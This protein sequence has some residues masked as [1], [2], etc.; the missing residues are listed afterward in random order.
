MATTRTSSMTSAPS[1]MLSLTAGM[2]AGAV[3][4]AV[5]YPAEFVKTKA[6]F[7]GSKAEAPKLTSII[8]QTI[9]QK[10]I[11]GLYSGAGALIAGNALK[12]GVRFMTYD[13]IKALLV[14]ERGKLSPVNG[15]LAGLG[16]GVCEAVI[17]VTPSETIKTKLIHD[18]ASL[19]PKYSGM[20]NGA[21]GIYKS[22]GVAGMYRG[23]VPTIMKQGANSMV[24][25]SSF[26]ALQDLALRFKSATTGGAK[27]LGSSETFTVGA[28]AGLITVYCT[29]PFDNIKTRMQALGAE[30]RYSNSLDCFTKIIREEGTTRLW[31]GTTP[32]LARL[33]L[34]GGIIF[35]VYGK[36][37]ELAGSF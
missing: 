4:G 21:V 34:S 3:E 25:F 19:N 10:G 23:L 36:V 14:D 16:A 9:R 31:G 6:Q 7:G 11:Q 1:Q 27:K 20:I 2:I 17:A 28:G 15:M 24:R 32:R 35:T 37:V 8:T 29:M 13:S 30:S 33:M 26:N 22:E 18:N 12:A 5:T